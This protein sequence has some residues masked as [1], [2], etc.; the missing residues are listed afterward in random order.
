VPV[1]GI[2]GTIPDSIWLGDRVDLR[3]LLITSQLALSLT[4]LLV[5]QTT[6]S[7]GWQCLFAFLMGACGIGFFL[8]NVNSAVQRSVRPEQVGRAQ[9]LGIGCVFGAP[10][11]SG[12]LFGAL[13]D[14]LGWR[15]AALWQITLLP[16][17][18]VVALAFVRTSQFTKGDTV[19]DH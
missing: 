18:A 11:F 19:H 5:Y 10:A 1:N 15:Q 8:P 2:S 14:Q 7:V 17:L 13:V 6:L 9:G 4:S 3:T 12:L 16:L